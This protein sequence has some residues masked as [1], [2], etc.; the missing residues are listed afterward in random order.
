MK[1]EHETAVLVLVSLS[2]EIAP[3]SGSWCFG[4]CSYVPLPCNWAIVWEPSAL[5]LLSQILPPLLAAELS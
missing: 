4:M 1:L 2:G 5:V 3:S